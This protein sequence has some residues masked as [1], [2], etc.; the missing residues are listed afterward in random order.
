MK[1]RHFLRNTG[2]LCGAA[3]LGQLGLFASRGAAASP[4]DYKAIVCVYLNGGN[5]SNNMI[6]PID[7][8]GYADYAT[9]RA[10]LALPRASLLPLAEAGGVLRFGLH[11]AL[12]GMQSLWN[13]GHLGVVANVGTLL[14]PLTQAQ[15]LGSATPRPDCLFSHIDQQR[16]WESAHSGSAGGLSSSGWGGRL[17]DQ[18]ASLNVNAAVPAMISTAGTNLFVTAA[19]AGALVIPVTGQFGLNVIGI[20]PADVARRSAISQ[21]LAVDRGADLTAAAQNVMSSALASCAVLNPI[22]NSTNGGVMARFASLTA[23]A[24][25]KQLLAIAKVIEAQSSLGARRQVFLVELTSFDTHTAQLTAQQAL[26][27]Q[28]DAGLAAFHGAM[29][30]IGISNSV[31]SFTLSDFGR[32]YAANSNA[33]SDHGWGSH[34][35]VAGGAVKG[36]KIYGTMPTLELAG[37]DD[38]DTKG[39]WI[40]TTSVD[41][42][43]APLATWFG[44]NATQ[45]AAVLPNLRSFPSTPLGYI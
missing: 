39:R 2:A 28:L 26:F 7:T 24:F 16:Q 36:G 12:P 29:S 20:T 14:Q 1:R 15:Y 13:A 21:L 35:L 5:D 6:V 34:Q 44:V 45:L 37:P 38:T 18:L 4:L 19:A 23:N 22:L 10:A 33:G 41:Q 17:T 31:T 25:A 40:P 42:F 9:N 8:A 30:D 32:T 3:A 27:E 11:A 43:A